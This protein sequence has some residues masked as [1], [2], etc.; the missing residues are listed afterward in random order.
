MRE[1]LKYASKSRAAARDALVEEHSARIAL[2][3]QFVQVSLILVIGA[4]VN[5]GLVLMRL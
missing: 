2:V 3:D 4:W 5:R 1:S